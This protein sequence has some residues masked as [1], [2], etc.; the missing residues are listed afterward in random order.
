VPGD[1]SG[2]PGLTIAGIGSAL[3]LPGG[4]WNCHHSVSAKRRLRG[5]DH[6]RFPPLSRARSLRSGWIA[7]PQRSGQFMSF[8]PRLQHRRYRQI[9]ARDLQPVIRAQA[10]WQQTRRLEQLR[11]ATGVAPL[12][13][14]RARRTASRMGASP[15]N[16]GDAMPRPKKPICKK[17][18]STGK[19]RQV[20]ARL[21]RPLQGVNRSAL[22]RPEEAE[23]GWLT[24]SRPKSPPVFPG[25]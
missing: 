12:S 21:G 5:D 25:C 8:E 6:T 9:R 19:A 1:R 20:L 22:P 10:E 15:R 18:P 7:L 23:D 17:M 11:V 2:R 3:R 14:C 16:H 4:L 24:S 13:I